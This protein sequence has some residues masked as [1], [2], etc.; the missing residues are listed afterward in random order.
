MGDDLYVNQEFESKE[1]V[2]K[3][4]KCYCMKNYRTAAL[5]ESKKSKLLM[6]CVNYVEGCPWRVR[7]MLPRWRDRWIVTRWGGKHTC[8]NP[9]LSQDHRQLDSDFICSCI[10][11]MVQVDP[12]T[13]IALIQERISGLNGYKVSYRKAWTAKQKA[14]VKLFGDWEDSYAYLERWLKYMLSFARGSF[15]RIDR[16][17]YIIGGELDDSRDMFHRV[18]WTFKQC[19]DAFKSC[20][21]VIQIDGTHLYGKYKGTML[22]A[23]TQDGNSQVLPLAFAIV[24]SETLSDW[25][26]FLR[27]L[28]RH[29]T[30]MQ[31]ICLISDRHISIKQAVAN[32]PD[33]WGPPRVYHVYC[34]RHIASNFNHKFHNVQLKKDLLNLGMFTRIIP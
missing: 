9:Y 14:I 28:H 1:S 17:P 20:K 30:D 2:Q 27:K 16:L 23:T 5:E 10:L 32:N 29:V 12:S 6:K 26:W 21:P 25:S 3:A 4:I 31:G 22:I 24:E 8:V 18:F 13:S 11:G 7:A 15:Y 33:L 34:I 19:T